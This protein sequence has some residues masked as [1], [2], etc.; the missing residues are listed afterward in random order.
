MHSILEFTGRESV[1]DQIKSKWSLV[2][3]VEDPAPQIILLTGERGVGKT[4]LAMEFYRWLSEEFDKSEPNGYWP[5]AIDFIDNEIIVNPPRKSCN[6]KNPIPY[7]WWGL[8]VRRDGIATFDDYLAPHM[9]QLLLNTIRRQAAF[10]TGGVFAKFAA[11]IGTAGLASLTYSILSAMIEESGVIRGAQKESS[12]KAALDVPQTRVDRILKHMEAVFCSRRDIM[13]KPSSLINSYAKI[14]AALLI[15]DAQN[16]REDEAFARFVEKLFYMSIAQKWPMLILVTHWQ[17]EL[18]PEVTPEKYSFA[19]ILRHCRHGSPDDNGPAAGVPGGFLT[20]THFLEIPL[21]KIDDLSRPLAQQLPGLTPVQAQ[22]LLAETDG[23]PR[24]LEQIIR[25]AREHPRF[26]RDRDTKRPLADDGLN[27]ILEATENHD[28]YKVVRARLRDAPEAVQEA[29]GLASLQGFEFIEDF[30]EAMGLAQLKREVRSDLRRAEDTYRW[31]ELQRAQGALGVGQFAERVFQQ[32]AEDV[33]QDLKSFEPGA[34]L[35]ITFRETVKALAGELI[36]TSDISV[37]GRQPALLLALEITAQLFATSADPDERSLAQNAL[38]GIMNIHLRRSSL[39]ETAAAYERLLK[40]EE[41][42]PQTMFRVEALDALSGAYRT[43][44]WPSKRTI[45][46]KRRV[47]EGYRLIG[48][49]GRLLAFAAEP[50]AVRSYFAEFKDK[51]FTECRADPAPKTDDQMEEMAHVLFLSAIR[52]IVPAL[53]ELSEVARTWRGAPPDEGDDPM[54]NAPFLLR[55]WITPE[56]EKVVRETLVAKGLIREDLEPDIDRAISDELQRIAHNLGSFV[57]EKFSR[58]E[59]FKILHSEGQFLSSTGRPDA[60]VDAMERALAISEDLGDAL[61]RIQTLS[62][63]G[64]V[65]GQ[66]GDLK[67]SQ[68]RLLKAAEVINELDAEPKFDVVEIVEGGTLRYKLAA[69]VRA[70]E[71][72]LIRQRIG[73]IGRLRGVYD[74]DPREAVG[75]LR[76]L[77]GMIGNVEGNLGSSALEAG[78]FNVAEKRF[79]NAMPCYIEIRDGER[80]AQ[81]L[82]N[83]ALATKKQQDLEKACKYWKE[84]ISVYKQLKEHDA[85]GL[86]EIR[87]DAAILRLQQDM[88]SAG[89]A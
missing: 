18:A 50:D 33:R 88:E 52:I 87:W 34:Q 16:W 9:A 5:D 82:T 74:V 53:L 39:E 63:L 27:T 84:S 85:G 3:D 22:S 54:S 45:A 43:L 86:N 30:V 20:D 42:E 57:G 73:M 38:I 77:V 66:N 37:P 79:E 26:F 14:P 29:I 51:S 69:D 72:S 78:E 81:T 64:L 11:D 35:Q 19:G 41:P 89:C 48:D 67:A 80:I 55:L 75:Q 46:I 32:V 71:E 59:H 15:D 7:L 4:R 58:R 24:F 61:Y 25:Y 65:H 49:E 60:A 36:G 13:A 44:G 68:V 47:Y 12:V 76:K 10:K 83:L 8:N 62:N 1:L 31:V 28:Y 2:S 17:R 40:I 21:K 23:N 6:F 70:D 56:D